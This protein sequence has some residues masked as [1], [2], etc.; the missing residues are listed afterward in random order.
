M[1]TGAGP[2]WCP[3]CRREVAPEQ[4]DWLACA[5][6]LARH[7]G[8]CW[9]E[10]GRCAA[11]E[12]GAPLARRDAERALARGEPA[13][14][15]RAPAPARASELHGLIQGYERAARPP[16]SERLLA[17]LAFVAAAPIAAEVR[18]LRHLRENAEEL[19][20]TGSRR[21]AGLERYRREALDDAERGARRRLRAAVAAF[22]VAVLSAFV[23]ALIEAS[24]AM[25]FDSDEAFVGLVGAAI[26]IWV[27]AHWTLLPLH[28]GA[29]RAHEARQ[30]YLGLL[31]RGVEEQ[32][33][34]RLLG[35]HAAAWRGAGTKLFVGTVLVHLLPLLTLPVVL[36]AWFAYAF[37]SLLALHEEREA[38]AA[39][40]DPRRRPRGPALRPER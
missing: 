5:R 6:C 38:T 10:T 31:E 11:C 2:V 39:E 28:W 17:L 12:G 18:L 7:H 13:A 23:G 24:R 9:G 34:G 32:R 21:D 33:A 35:E 36:P 37:K 8:A 20:P 25:S 14:V 29:V 16:L 22:G 40:L 15:K 3:H 27:I 19:H 1:R 4:E 26:A 30:L